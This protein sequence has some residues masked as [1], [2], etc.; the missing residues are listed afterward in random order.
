MY[1]AET[2]NQILGTLEDAEFRQTVARLPHSTGVDF[3]LNRSRFLMQEYDLYSFERSA[4]VAAS[5]LRTDRQAGLEAIAERV[6][7]EPKKIFMETSW[8]DRQ[9]AFSRVPQMPLRDTPVDYGQPVRVGIALEVLGNGRGRLQTAW[10]HPI[11]SVREL[12]DE[13]FLK[14]IGCAKKHQK[15]VKKVLTLNWSLFMIDIDVNQRT[16]LTR[17]E[18]LEK[19]NAG[20]DECAPYMTAQR[21]ISNRLGEIGLIDRAFALYRLNRICSYRIHPAGES[22]LREMANLS[23]DEFEHVLDTM[24]SDLDGEIVF[25]LALAALLELDNVDIFQPSA[26]QTK[27]TKDRSR[28]QWGNRSEKETATHLPERLGVVSLDIAPD[29][30][31]SYFQEAHPGKSSNAPGDGNRRSPVA[32]PVQGH[33]FRARNGKIVYRKPHWRGKDQRKRISSVRA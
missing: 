13:R 12:A 16:D 6:L 3:A 10:S 14:E 27:K 2:V 24:R 32:H 19:C 26:G 29:I 21:D 15:A 33:L 23:G 25:G 28:R 22:Y 5:D 20:D 30:V 18:F 9:K 8:P 7:A 11:N 31:A 4:L 1:L 17:A